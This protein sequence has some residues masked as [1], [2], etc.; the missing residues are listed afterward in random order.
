[1]SET[2]TTNP[3]APLWSGW[4][5]GML[6]GL[7]A[8]TA[9]FFGWTQTIHLSNRWSVLSSEF[10]TVCRD[11]QVLASAVDMLMEGEEGND[12][13]RAAFPQLAPRPYPAPE[14][15]VVGLG[16]QRD[17]ARAPDSR[18]FPPLIELDS[19]SCENMP[20]PFA[21]NVFSR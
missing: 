9:M 11:Q 10:Q 19:Y 5:L 7:I 21:P 18:T 3:Y 20:G 2:T 17:A 8:L 6:L 12:R 13:L 16:Q 4:A 15:Q 1:M 14:V